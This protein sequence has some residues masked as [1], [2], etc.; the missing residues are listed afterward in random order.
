MPFYM[1]TFHLPVGEKHEKMGRD[2]YEFLLGI[3]EYD[4]YV[5][6]LLLC[7]GLFFLF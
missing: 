7:L 5:G 3:Y 4:H 1:D 2:F 6:S